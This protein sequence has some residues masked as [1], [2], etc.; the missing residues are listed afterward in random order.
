MYC[1]IVWATKGRHT[2]IGER[3]EAVIETAFR[4]TFTELVAI[5]HAIGFMP[6]HVHVAASVPPKISTADFVRR[7]KGASSRAVNLDAERIQKPTFGWQD[8]Y[9]VLSFGE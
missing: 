3:E 7:L 2:M 5:P 6:D 1:H 8:G 4:S 9:G